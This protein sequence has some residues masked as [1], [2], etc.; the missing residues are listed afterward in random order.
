MSPTPKTIND[1]HQKRNLPEMVIQNLKNFRIFSSIEFQGNHQ[2]MSP[3]YGQPAMSKTV[4]IG[5]SQKQ[6][7]SQQFN[8]PMN[9]YSDEAIADSA[10]ANQAL[11]QSK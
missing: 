4:N 7:V 1:V 2:Q 6:I 9:M 3:N 11:L 5:G 8:S 10:V